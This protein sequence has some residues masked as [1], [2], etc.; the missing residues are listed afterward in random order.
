MSE[1]NSRSGDIGI[2]GLLGCIFVTLKLCSVIDWQ[3]PFVILPFVA[4][5]VLR[6]VIGKILT[7]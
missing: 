3:W 2:L 5:A 7:A 1:G 4:R 6:I